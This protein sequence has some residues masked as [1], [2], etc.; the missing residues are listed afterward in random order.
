MTS[1][2]PYVHNLADKCSFTLRL[3]GNRSRDVVALKADSA[4]ALLEQI[5]QDLDC[6]SVYLVNKTSSPPSTACFHD[7]LYQDGLLQN[8]SQSE[9]SD[10]TVIVKAACGKDFSYLIVTQK[11]VLKLKE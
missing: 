6:G 9:R 7:C 2:D 4:D 3:P 10:C 11:S 1:G 8:C 5:C